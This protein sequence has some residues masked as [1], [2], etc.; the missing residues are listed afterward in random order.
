M[1]LIDATTGSVA[2][3]SYIERNLIMKQELYNFEV[4]PMVFPAEREVELTVRSLGGRDEF[5][6]SS[7]R[8]EIIAIDTYP[9]V[10]NVSLTVSPEADNCLRFSN[11]FHGEKE[12]YIR[13]YDG[14][15]RIVQ[16]SVY[17]LGSD[18]ACRL[19]FRGDL[20]MH[21]CRSDGG[22]IPA[23]VAANYR[24]K[25][26]DFLSITDHERYYPSL[27]AIEAFSSLDTTYTLVP[28]EEVHLPLTNVHIVNFGGL[29]S[30]NG[31]LNDI[32][33]YTEVDGDPNRLSAV[34]KPG[35]VRT[36]EE[37]CE[38]IRKF[39]DELTVPQDVD[40]LSY[41]TCVW[42]FNHIREAD[43]LG[44]FAHPYWL[45][46]VFH[47]SEPL[48]R[49]L[50][51]T[52]PFDAFEVL[53][54]ENYYQ[55]NGYQTVL[56]YEEWKRG[57]VHAIVGSTDSHNSTE[58]NRDAD[59]CSTIVFSPANERKALIDSIK[60][61]YSVAVD[62]ISKEYRLVGEERFQRYA[63]F[64][65]DNWYP[66]HDA[67]CQQEGYWMKAYVTHSDEEAETVLKAISPRVKALF[68]KFFLL[69]DN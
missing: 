67:V 60:N 32:Q 42:A 64:L 50:M 38:E 69:A 8:I 22:E 24:A 56:Y 5:S 12:H 19:P 63:R 30:I 41:A 23:V 18:M 16:L 46:N 57:R 3:T 20:H 25:G 51:E 68:D 26:Y 31:L 54:G 13:I 1:Q 2:S 9:P 55:Q 61:R 35:R 33:S 34:G 27:E 10:C 47:V 21:T 37:Y 44:I 52:H 40:P 53:G 4:F 7:Y 15:R 14:E 45:A 28:G 6:A 17:S 59:I 36:R 43:G 58:H 66:R 65:M 49:Y 29:H 39:A 48:T 11:V 62:T